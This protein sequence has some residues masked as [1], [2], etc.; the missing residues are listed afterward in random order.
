MHGHHGRLPSRQHRGTL[1]K[2][3]AAAQA[4]YTPSLTAQEIALSGFAPEDFPD[5]SVDLWPENWPAWQLFCRVSTQWRMAPMGGITGL[6]YAPLFVLL[7]RETQS[8]TDP[9]KAWDELF[10]DIRHLESV[11]IETLRDAK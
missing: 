5:E 7:D 4:A 10:D 1:G 11:A 2:L 8:A 6:D 9:R 3:T